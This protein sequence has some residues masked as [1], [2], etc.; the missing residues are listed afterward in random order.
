MKQWIGRLEIDLI[1]D[2]AFEGNGNYWQTSKRMCG[3][4]RASKPVKCMSNGSDAV[5]Y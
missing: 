1:R 4:E 3:E 5:N 2:N